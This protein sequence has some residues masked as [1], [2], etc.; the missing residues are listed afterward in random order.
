LFVTVACA[1]ERRLDAGVEASGPH[2]FAVRK[3]APSSEAQLASTASRPAL[4]TL[5]NAPLL[6]QDGGSCR[7]DLPGGLSEIF[8]QMGL[9]R[10]NQLDPPQQ[11]RVLAHNEVM[12]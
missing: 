6:G 3:S 8:F 1:P 5:R 11:F 4:M 12:E 7:S 9:D 2:D 10:A